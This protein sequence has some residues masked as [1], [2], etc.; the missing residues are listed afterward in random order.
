M[1]VLAFDKKILDLQ[2]RIP[3]KAADPYKIN[4][5]NIVKLLKKLGDPHKKIP[6]VIHIAGTNGKGSTH[7]YLKAFFEAADYKVHAY[8][9]PHLV[10]FTE[11]FYIAGRPADEKILLETLLN[12]E[13]NCNR[14]EITFFELTTA[15]AFVL[16]SKFQA[17]IVLLETGL[18]GRLDATNVI[19]KPLASVITSIS[20]DHQDYLGNSLDKIAFE[21]AGIIK[22]NCP[23]F[24]DQQEDIVTTAIKSN[25]L[26][27]QADFYQAGHDWSY[28]ILDRESWIFHHKNNE[29]TLP[30]PALFG[31][32][33][34]QNAS[35]AIATLLNLKS[36]FN[37]V[38]QNLSD[39]LKNTIWPGRLQ[40]L[41]KGYFSKDI[42]P[43]QQIWIDGGHNP[44]AGE[45]L[46]KSLNYLKDDIVF[47]VGMLETKDA[48]GFLTE[49]KKI[50]STVL[51][52]PIPYNDNIISADKL[53]EI[54]EKIGFQSI[55]CSS[56]HQALKYVCT[57][58]P[59]VNNIVICGSLYLIG[60][61]LKE[62]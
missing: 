8:T 50:S 29:F 56:I 5:D 19:D 43:H 58:F 2:N 17:D 21:K 13:K 59:K 53:K 54:A 11:R 18:G 1:S 33:Q 48:T 41:P 24:V 32:H 44:A 22:E 47:I 42:L 38:E 25:A 15:A 40:H 35:L 30:T 16:F 12:V 7:A 46:A 14:D 37:I 28:T 20:Y 31:N 57:S 45:S 61:I 3:I 6:P 9:S 23:V 34:Y 26:K 51:T 62:N 49:L 36:H 55:A 60:A 10:S 52:I 39:G 4:T 27:K